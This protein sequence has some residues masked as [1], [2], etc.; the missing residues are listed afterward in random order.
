[1]SDERGEGVQYYFAHERDAIRLTFGEL[2]A[3]LA[4]LHEIASAKRT[5]FQARL[6]N[7]QRLGIPQGVASGRGKTAYYGPGQVVEMALALELTQLGLLPER[8]VAVFNLNKFPISQAVSMASRAILEK[9]G[10][11][12]G[13]ERLDEN[14]TIY[15]GALMREGTE[16]TD[17][18]SMFLY[19]DPTALASLTDI[20]ERYEDQASA[21][22]F[23][24]GAGIVRENIVKWTAGPYI[25]RLALINLTAMLWELVRRTKPERQIRF[26]KEV[27]DWADGLQMDY[28]EETVPE[29]EPEP[30]NL[31]V[32]N[33]PEEVVANAELLKNLKGLPKP[34]AE[35]LVERAQRM[36]KTGELPGDD[37][38]L[39][40][41]R[42]ADMTDQ[43][44]ENEIVTQLVRGGLPE[45][46]A[47]EAIEA[48]R[49]DR[50]QQRAKA[51]AGAKEKKKR[52]SRN[53][54]GN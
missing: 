5:Q 3:R 29:D 24:G 17:P 52:R 18:L 41:K 32:I 46:V 38:G 33:T 19:F 25:R 1:M 23:Y 8:V 37:T 54:D 22:F 10:F 49:A 13:H 42:W 30:E 20:P 34:V 39:T 26:C 6:R 2:E 44:V 51:A 47:R 48:S 36:I 15:H 21:T 4:R 53:G 16:D 31:V 43:E 35:A 7:F 11:R 50:D 40:G 14:L 9:G 12:P 45:F 27:Q 28:L